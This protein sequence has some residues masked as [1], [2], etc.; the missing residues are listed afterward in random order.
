MLTQWGN[1]LDLL[2]ISRF[3]VAQGR[4]NIPVNERW[5]QIHPPHPS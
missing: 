1:L 4:E 5:V 2:F 3:T